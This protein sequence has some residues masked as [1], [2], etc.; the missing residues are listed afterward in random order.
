MHA[1]FDLYAAQAFWMWIG[2]AAILLGVETLTGSG[3]LL[4]PAGSAG[5]VG[6]VAVGAHQGLPRDMVIF[7]VLTLVTTF[8]GRRYLRPAPTPPQG[9]FNDRGARLVGMTGQ[10]VA[11]FKDG[12]GRVFVDGAEWIAETDAGAAVAAGSRVEV[13]AVIGGGR[14]KVRIP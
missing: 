6:V 9:E 4:W 10:A 14:L 13:S 3:Y 7:A 8:V 5:I 11:D 1:I 12:H 2:L